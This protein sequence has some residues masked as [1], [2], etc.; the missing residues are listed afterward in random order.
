MGRV[1][2]GGVGRVERRD[3]WN[4]KKE[5]KKVRTTYFTSFDVE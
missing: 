1:E 2:R 3:G 5:D 4:G